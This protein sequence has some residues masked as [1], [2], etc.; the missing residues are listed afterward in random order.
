[1]S[2]S[3]E[4]SVDPAVDP[5]RTV[6]VEDG[7]TA[8]EQVVATKASPRILISW[9]AVLAGLAVAISVAWMMLLLGTSIGVSIGDAT[10]ATTVSTGFSIATMVWV[11]LSGLIPFFLGGM[12]A[13]RLAGS[14]DE[15]V[16]VMHGIT[17]WAIGIVLMLVM[18]YWGVTSLVYTSA[19]ALTS[20]AGTATGAV[21]SAAKTGGSA[22]LQTGE[23]V[24]WS[25]E[26]IGDTEIASSIA[27]QIKREALNSVANADSDVSKSDLKSA[28]DNLDKETLAKVATELI[29]GDTQGAKNALAAQTDLTRSQINSLIGTLERVISEST[30]VEEA[31]QLID[32]A[33]KKSSKEA[34]EALS[35]A[36][37][38]SISQAE[39]RRALNELDAA[40]WQAVAT[41]VITGRTQAAKD[42]LAVNTNLS[43]DQ[44]EAVVKNVKQ[45]TAEQVDEFQQTANY[46]AEQATT[47]AQWVLWSSFIF[48]ALGLVCAMLGGF[49]GAANVRHDIK[50]VAIHRE[51]RT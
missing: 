41:Q 11:I 15:T 50:K 40:Q 31:E 38:S 5:T 4:P 36:A 18:S 24:M 7:V 42:T 8:Q 9:G 28:L 47:Y 22:L 14:E 2:E 23:A 16:G 13:A 19:S 46:Y 34:A 10:D 29:D 45:E 32:Q 37:G 25:G 35:Y 17:V 39:A 48:A 30:T 3:H 51:V 20:A 26:K 12:L 33:I 49:T 6:V 21:S 44:I 43:E 1:M 27:A